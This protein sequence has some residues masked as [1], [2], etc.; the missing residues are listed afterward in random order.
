MRTILFFKS[1]P[2]TPETEFTHFQNAFGIDL[3]IAAEGDN[4]FIASTLALFDQARAEPPDE[5]M[6]PEHGLDQ[7]VQRGGKIIA[8]ADMPDFV[9]EDGFKVDIFEI[10]G[11]SFGPD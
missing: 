2:V 10:I 7:H 5:R 4:F 3:A 8:A 1:A 9:G 6:K 11:D